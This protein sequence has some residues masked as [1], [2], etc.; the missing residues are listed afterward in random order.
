MFRLKMV[1]PALLLAAALPNS[2]HLQSKP[3]LPT[4][5]QAV[6]TKCQTVAGICPAAPAPVGSVCACGITPG[7]IR[8]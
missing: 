3:K 4:Y 5:A 6:G 8:Q 7:F 2:T 1:L